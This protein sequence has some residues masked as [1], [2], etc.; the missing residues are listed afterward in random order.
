MSTTFSSTCVRQ[1][2]CVCKFRP[3]KFSGYHNGWR[4]VLTSVFRSTKPLNGHMYDAFE[5]V[6]R[7][8]WLA[9]KDLYWHQDFR[10]VTECVDPMSADTGEAGSQEAVLPDS[11]STIDESPNHACINSGI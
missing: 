2:P 9:K 10:H 11:P 6:D 1:W 3:S 5:R 7:G 4:G 8:G